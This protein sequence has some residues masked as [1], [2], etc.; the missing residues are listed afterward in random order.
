MSKV[1][2]WY[3]CEI[4]KQGGHIQKYRVQGTVES[5]HYCIMSGKKTVSTLEQCIVVIIEYMGQNLP[6]APQVYT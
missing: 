3:R 1:Y 4:Y 2:D 6:H 5:T